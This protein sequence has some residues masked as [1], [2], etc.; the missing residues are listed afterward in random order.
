MLG[1]REICSVTAALP[2]VTMFICFVS[3]VV[4]QFDDV[5]ET[6]CRVNT[7]AS[8]HLLMSDL[9][10]FLRPFTV[11]QVFNFI[12]SISA[13]TGVSPQRYFWRI[14]IA[15]H[16]GPRF[17]IAVCYKSYY[18]HMLSHVKNL[19]VYNKAK[20]LMNMAFWLHLVEIT[21]L[22]GVTYISNRENY[23]EYL[24]STLN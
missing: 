4:F 2:L 8:W 10:I 5:H 11:L 16:V 24:L 7:L 18:E 23:S 15:L 13:I 6:H 12:P 14:S 20:M 17:I 21:S 3:A 9:L 19:P 1:F 22:C